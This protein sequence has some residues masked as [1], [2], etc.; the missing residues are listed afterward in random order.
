[1]GI[2]QRKTPLE[3]EWEALR[4]REDAFLAARVEKEDTRLNQLLA[5]KVPP[6]LQ[7]TLD[8]GFY[9]AFQLIFEKGT[10]VIEKT[11]R[12]DQLEQ[13]SQ[14]NRYAHDLRR[15]RKTI[16]AFSKE[17]RA[18]GT[19][20]VL[21]SGV[22]GI[23]MGLL[24]VGLPD[25]PLF[26]GMV[27]RTVYE[28]ALGY[29]YGYDTEEERYFILL[30]IQGAVSH[31]EAL[32]A[33]DAQVNRYIWSQALPA[34]YDRDAQLQ[35]TAGALSKELLYMKFLQGIPLVGAVGGAYDVVYM[36]QVS[37][38]A[39]LKYQRRLLLGSGAQGDNL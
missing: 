3:K 6:G 5:E 19:K 10:G 34:G 29:G 25:I 38:Y 39:R 12:R 7:D 14:V 37:A 2:L 16:K 21:L 22:S 28:I 13:T 32:E 8:K 33:L 23:G 27:L 9:K 35:K 20:G 26:T 24:G 18:A 31:G 17:A 30:L 36:K 11:Y 1:M 15:D 4:K